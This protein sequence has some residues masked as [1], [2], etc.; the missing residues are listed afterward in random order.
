MRVRLSYTVELEEMF[1]EVNRLLE[2]CTNNIK[3]QCDELDFVR[4]N[5]S[6]EN[7]SNVSDKI[8]ALRTELIKR[9]ALLEECHEILRSFDE[10]TKGLEGQDNDRDWETFE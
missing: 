2:K 7:Y 6:D 9:D 8:L 4:K 10:Y 3:T 1:N 5:L